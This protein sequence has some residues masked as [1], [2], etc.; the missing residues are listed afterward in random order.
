MNASTAQQP[1]QPPH[2]REH[3]HEHDAHH[4]HCLE[5]PR[6]ERLNY[7]Y[8]QM[9]GVREFRAEQAY[10]REKH[11]LHNRYLHGYGVVCGLRVT[12][13]VLKQGEC[14]RKP[15]PPCVTVECGLAIDCAG[16]ELVLRAAAQVKLPE[17]RECVWIAICYRETAFQPVRPAS[18]GDCAGAQLD[19]VNAMTREDVCIRVLEER[20]EHHSPC[21]ACGDTCCEQCLVLARVELKAGNPVR[22]E[23]IDNTIR[24]PLS[25]FETAR[26][27]RIGWTHGATYT[28]EEAQQ[29]LERG[30]YMHFSRKIHAETALASGVFDLWVIQGGRGSR[31]LIQQIDIKPHAHQHS[32]LVDWVS[33]RQD[34]DEVLQPGDRVLITL[35]SSFVLDECCRSLDGEHVTGIPIAPGY[36]QWDRAECVF[37]PP[38]RQQPPRQLL[39]WMSGNGNPAGTF[40]SWFFIEEYQ[41]GHSKQ[42]G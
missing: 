12:P 2:E 22:V 26:V 20:P 36:E 21:S 6:F 39:P 15:P 29:L 38:C 33:F 3:E 32:G 16:N 9:L 41:H 30:L 7:F 14:D 27:D 23:D 17:N 19:C 28:R 1:G 42:R 25:L 34:T 35:R 31:G 11:K 8:G 37:R 13:C 40:E 18:L 5:I 4:E 10:L 24:R